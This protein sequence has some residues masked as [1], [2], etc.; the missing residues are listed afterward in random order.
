[1]TTS[2]NATDRSI[3]E[4]LIKEFFNHKSI[5]DLEERLLQAPFLSL[6]YPRYHAL[7]VFDAKPIARELV[8]HY[9]EFMFV[10][11][12]LFSDKPATPEA[13]SP[14]LPP[15][16]D[17]VWRE[18]ILD[19][20]GYDAFCFA[21]FGKFLHRDANFD[22]HRNTA[23]REVR[24]ART[25]IVY[26][27]RLGEKRINRLIAAG[28][29]WPTRSFEEPTEVSRKRRAEARAQDPVARQKKRGGEDS[30]ETED[31][32]VDIFIQVC[33][34][35]DGEGSIPKRFQF[36]LGDTAHHVKN[37]LRA[38]CVPPRVGVHKFTLFFDG[39]PLDPEKTLRSYGVSKNRV[40]QVRKQ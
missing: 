20:R 31:Q 37:S 28:L 26:A 17:Q 32:P 9:C 40:L 23:L 19:T 6:R 16:I 8:E 4:K 34:K 7:G 22:L 11:K 33:A 2:S 5:R 3:Y 39:R 25:T 12:E 14:F 10:L 36:R 35:C 15:L 29:W 30:T 13:Y 38:R 24:R 18:H 21:I 27:R 1:M